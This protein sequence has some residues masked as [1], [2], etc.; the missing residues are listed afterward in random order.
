MEAE[1][2]AIA[3]KA[4]KSGSGWTA[5]CPAHD[6][7]NPS[8]SI[9]DDGNGKPL[10]YCQSGCSQDEVIS[11][12]KA[13]DLWEL[14][15]GLS[16]PP[17]V[18]SKAVEKQEKERLEGYLDTAT[19]ASKEYKNYSSDCSQS[20]YLKR[21]KVDVFGIKHDGNKLVV[22]A[23]DVDGK[24]W[25]YQTIED[26]GKKLFKFG[27]RKKGC[28]HVIGDIVASER[29]FVSEGYAT[30]A[31][32]YM[33]TEIT[34]IVAFDSG[35]IEPVID[36]LKLK[37]PKLGIT[38]VAD[39]DRWKEKNAGKAAAEGVAKK[40]DIEYV[41]PKFS[42]ESARRKPTDF[43]DLHMLEGLDE[44]ARQL[45]GK[46]PKLKVVNIAEFLA[47]EIPPREMLLSPILPSQGLAMLYAQRGVGKTYVSLSIAVAIAS[48]K[49]LFEGKWQ[50]DKASKVLFIDGEMPANVLQE[51]LAKL[52]AN[53]GEFDR[54]NLNILTSDFQEFG[55]PD[56]SQKE[57]Q[58]IVEEFIDDDT[59]VIILDNLSTLCRSGKE[60]D[61]DS[62]KQIQEWILSLRRKGK[63]VLLVH[64]ANK[65]GS[66]RGTSKRED[67]LDTVITLKRPVDYEND[68]GARFEIHY[69][70]ARGFYGE[71]AEPFEVWFKDDE[72]WVTEIED[73]EIKKIIE[74]R[75]MGLTQKEIAGE[76]G[77]SKA[78]ICRR[79]KKS[80]GE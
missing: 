2:I 8:L 70:K 15:E 28:F 60:N 57:G 5:C 36:A 23:Q 21:K 52:I 73:N 43:N 65:S 13:L 51:R 53:H 16:K 79:L 6:D 34:T 39:D 25:T 47:I 14:G 62:W 33:A 55:I 26:D 18:V 76:L 24:I 72:W 17:L 3:L 29:I 42:N 64:H 58:E 46:K 68:Q 27:G 7:R 12:L 35:N 4:R 78:T 9:N 44:V 66:Q 59:K 61:E 67:V 48:G 37:Y 40:H 1:K 77:V 32:V 49:P 69:E 50:C 71:D 11:A 80:G 63:S 22:S 38:I 30:A 56:L 74:L 54:N 41:L 45:V 20:Q 31:S 10:L 19:Q 75:G